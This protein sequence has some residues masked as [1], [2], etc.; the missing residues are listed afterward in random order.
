MW[1]L[2]L[3]LAHGQNGPASLG[4]DVVTCSPAPCVLP[5]TEVL[6]ERMV[7]AAVS[8]N[9]LNANTLLLGADRSTGCDGSGGFELSTD[10][11][12]TWKFSTCMANVKTQ[13][14]E[15]YAYG[16]PMVGYDLNGNA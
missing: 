10:G 4:N 5:V 16:Q 11:G 8:V 2:P 9:P 7:N 6:P 12:S 3:S 1:T 13:K 14:R 15:Y